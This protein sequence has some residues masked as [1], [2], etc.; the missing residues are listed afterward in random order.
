MNPIG[1]VI[2]LAYV[3]I[4]AYGVGTASRRGRCECGRLRDARYCPK[5]CRRRREG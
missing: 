2:I 3:V 4:V 5:G 1:W